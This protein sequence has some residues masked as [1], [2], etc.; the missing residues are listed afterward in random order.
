MSTFSIVMIVIIVILIAACI[1]LYFFGKKAEKRQAEQQEQMDAVAQ[2]VSML[3][4]DKKKMKLKESGLPASVIES[5][6]KY[7]RRT[8][9]PVVKAKV[10]PRIMTLMCEGKVFDVL[11]V[12]KEVKAVVS[13]LYIT[14]IKSV[15]G[16]SIE[17]PQKKKGFFSRFKK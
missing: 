11:P 15:R 17:Q 5:T 14:G 1:A 16:G 13:G 2:T 4:I 9:V 6:P 10:G 8:K 12:K 7:L 3:I